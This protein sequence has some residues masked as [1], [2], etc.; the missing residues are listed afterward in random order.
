MRYSHVVLVLIPLLAMSLI[1]VAGVFTYR[2]VNTVIYVSE[3]VV[4]FEL[5]SNA[6]KPDIG[7]GRTIVVVLGVNKTRVGIQIHPTYQRNYYRN[8]TIVVNRDTKP[9]A[10]Y[11]T[12]RSRED[13]LPLNSSVA[14]IIYRGDLLVSTIDLRQTPIN[15][16]IYIGYIPPNETW[17][18][19]FFVEIPEGVSI[20]GRRLNITLD[21]VYTPSTEIPP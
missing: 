16:P 8:I 21:L 12:T 15:T 19:D 4:F 1:A 14:M 6:N 5:G 18:I 20:T 9:L 3:P 10:V 2:H 13:T 17:R 11:F 7:P